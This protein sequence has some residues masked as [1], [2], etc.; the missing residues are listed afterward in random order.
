MA[1]TTFKITH[2]IHFMIRE[3][4][5]F[6][7]IN[8]NIAY[9]DDEQL[10]SLAELKLIMQENNLSEIEASGYYSDLTGTYNIK[11]IKLEN[12]GIIFIR[13]E[14]NNDRNT[15]TTKLRMIQSNNV[16]FNNEPDVINDVLNP[17]FVGAEQFQLF[18]KIIKKCL[19][20]KNEIIE[21]NSYFALKPNESCI[22][23]NIEDDEDTTLLINNENYDITDLVENNTSEEKTYSVNKKCSVLFLRQ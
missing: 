15:K 12:E 5:K 17:P 14:Q 11:G 3:D 20:K 7:N 6:I 22:V 23:I 4:D 10:K 16:S 21:K 19:F 18:T 1:K 2:I 8:F 9:K 13:S